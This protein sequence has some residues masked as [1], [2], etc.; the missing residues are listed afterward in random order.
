[1]GEALPAVTVPFSRR[2]TVRRPARVSGVE[3][4]RTVSSRSR[5][6]PGTGATSESY[7]P[8][9][10]ARAVRR[11]ERAAN[12]SWRSREMPKRSRSSSVASPSETVHSGGIASLIRRQPS[13]VFAAARSCRGNG[14]VVLGS[15]HGARDMDSTPPTSTTSASPTSI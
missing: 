5:S 7:R 1:M 14:R 3:S 11:C 13:V 10:H 15:T 9:S 12:S 4:G 8:S 6:V 2:N